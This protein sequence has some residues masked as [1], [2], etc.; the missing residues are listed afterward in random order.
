MYAVHSP[1]P[2]RLASRWWGRERRAAK[3]WR[4]LARWRLGWWRLAALCSRAG[5]WGSTRPHTAVPSLP[6]AGRSP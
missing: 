6:G 5:R 3:G 4:W 1:R 2:N